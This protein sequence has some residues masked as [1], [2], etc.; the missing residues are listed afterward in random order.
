VKE[1]GLS[2]SEMLDEHPWRNKAD[3]YVG[4]GNNA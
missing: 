2:Q 4:L 1:E 3:M